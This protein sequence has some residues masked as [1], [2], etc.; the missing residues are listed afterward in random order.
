MERKANSLG[1]IVAGLGLALGACLLPYLVSSVYSVAG[2]LFQQASAT[3]WLW[4]DW[5]STLVDPRSD[6]YRLLVE[7]PVCCAGVL[8]LLIVVLGAVWMVGLR[9]P[10]QDRAEE[11]DIYPEMEEGFGENEE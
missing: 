9:E 11:Q 1:C 3:K 10:D 2:I 5:V 7:A 6:Q 4:G 8:A